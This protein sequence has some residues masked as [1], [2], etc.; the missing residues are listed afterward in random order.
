MPL[1]VTLSYFYIYQNA[2]IGGK[3][4]KNKISLLFLPL[5]ILN[6]CKNSDGNKS[7]LSQTS[8]TGVH[9]DSLSLKTTPAKH[10]FS[11]KE[12]DSINESN[13]KIV[14]YEDKDTLGKAFIS[15][16]DSSIDA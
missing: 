16:S 11:S 1:F 14:N 5:V 7:P 2:F 9:Q 13:E 6:S 15:K 3:S 8:D 10:V 12:L 4:L